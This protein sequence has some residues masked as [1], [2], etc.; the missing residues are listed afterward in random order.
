MWS[1]FIKVFPQI[2]G[3][4]DGFN[5]L[6]LGILFFISLIIFRFFIESIQD[7][8]TIKFLIKKIQIYYQK[9]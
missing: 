3:N 9:I 2:L 8:N 1:R 4:Y 6:G 5:Y 7:E